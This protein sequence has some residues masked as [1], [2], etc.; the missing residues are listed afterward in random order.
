[1]K[2]LLD[3]ERMKYPNT[4]LYEYCNQLGLA[5]QRVVKK[6]HLSFYLPENVQDIFGKDAERVIQKSL[7]KLFIPR[8]D[9]D[10][11]HITYQNTG[12]MKGNKKVKKV[13]TI[14]DLNF[15]YEKTDPQKIQ[16]NLRKVQQNIDRADHL[17][18]ISNYAKNDVLKHLDTH[19]KPFDVIYNGVHVTEPENYTDPSYKPQKE[20]LFSIGTVLPKKNFHVLPALLRGNDYELIIAG[21]SDKGYVDK[22]MEMA[23]QYDV[24]DRVHLPGPI[25][26]EDKCWYLKNCKAFMFPSIAEGFGIPVIEA[27]HF[28]KP[29]FLSTR[30]SL[31]EVGGKYAYYFDNFEPDYMQQVFEKGREDY[32]TNNRTSDIVKHALAF[33]WDKA[34]SEYYEVYKSVI[35]R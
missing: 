28:G 16:K 12:Y 31:P 19:N 35:N 34:A 27:M 23:K 10:I 21:K 11:W 30:T 13:L 22:I 29:V 7:H 5:L 32:E 17:V 20:F 1:M 25:S 33:N 3:C 14:H 9:A 8:F 6:D 4:G 18:A 24:A 26:Y 2:I 15:L